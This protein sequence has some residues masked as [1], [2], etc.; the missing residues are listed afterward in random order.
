MSR[1]V[2]ISIGAFSV[3]WGMRTVPVFWKD[4]RLDHTAENILDG[5]MFKPE[6]LQTLLA[7]AEFRENLGP[8]GGSQKR[9]DHSA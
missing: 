8:S 2:L 9:C 4:A 3:W 6:I 5:E 7:D 1:G